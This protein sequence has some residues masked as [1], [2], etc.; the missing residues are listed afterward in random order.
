VCD[1][2]QAGHW[3]VIIQF[4]L[5]SALLLLVVAVLTAISGYVRLAV[6]IGSGVLNSNYLALLLAALERTAGSIVRLALRSR[7]AQALNLVRTRTRQLGRGFIHVFRVFV[8]AARV[9]IVLDL[10]AL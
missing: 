6:L 8:M 7:A 10:F 4:G 2:Q 3:Q 1:G 9:L 5:N